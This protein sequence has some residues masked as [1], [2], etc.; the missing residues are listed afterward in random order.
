MDRPSGF[1]V[2]VIVPVHIPGQ[3][4]VKCL[5][6][7][8]LLN[9]AA[10]EVI[11]VADGTEEAVELAESAGFKSVLIPTAGGPAR[12]RNAGGRLAKHDILF[13][14]DADVMVES[15]AIS[16]LAESFRSDP[17]LTAVIG[18]YD[19]LPGDPSFL[20]QY[21]NLFHHFIHQEAE[22]KASTFWGACGAI[23][24]EDFL[25]VGGFDESYTHPSVEDIELGYRLT[26]GGYAIRLDRS[27]Q[28]KH[29]KHWSPWNM[30]KT[31]FIRRALP[32]TLLMLRHKHFV[33]D[34]NLR[35]RH[36][37]SVI[38]VFV[39]V[40]TVVTTAIEIR[41][42]AITLAAIV[43]LL[44]LNLETYAFFM[45]KRGT[46]FTL[47]VLPWHWLYYFYGGLAF[48]IGIFWHVTLGRFLN[49]E[50]VKPAHEGP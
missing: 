31:D 26:H 19:D 6:S 10:A 22:E 23:R 20:S 16:R 3:A 33:S 11:V 25:A 9:P 28:V 36:R 35:L 32:W 1:D 38:C 24:R 46:W 15:D 21:R 5:E 2:S 41:S 45:K 50:P 43:A 47:R 8:N 37:L 4:F 42:L 30:V 48:A 13:F 34:L 29:N 12:A 27:L 14:L 17:G 39:L 49:V 7:L 18:S 40:A 44:T